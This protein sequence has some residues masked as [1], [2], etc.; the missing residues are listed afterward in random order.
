MSDLFTVST[1]AELKGLLAM[2]PDDAPLVV[3]PDHL[4]VEVAVVTNPDDYN[5]VTEVWFRELED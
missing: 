1:V 5:S 4:P 2:L 3:G